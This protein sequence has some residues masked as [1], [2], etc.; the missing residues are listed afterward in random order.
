MMEVPPPAADDE[1]GRDDG[2]EAPL[3]DAE[4]PSGREAIEAGEEEAGDMSDVVDCY[5]QAEES[6]VRMHFFL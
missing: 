4:P 1:A 6:K 2:R 5:P 3:S